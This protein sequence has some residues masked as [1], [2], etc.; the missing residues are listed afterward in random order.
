MTRPAALIRLDAAGK[1][2]AELAGTPS[3]VIEAFKA[4][5][6][7]LKV[8]ELLFAISARGILKKQK[9]PKASDA[10]KS[11]VKPKGK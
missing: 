10:P 3:Q 2:V 8:G 5:R 4:K 9:G 11:K 6:D 1:Q 7:S